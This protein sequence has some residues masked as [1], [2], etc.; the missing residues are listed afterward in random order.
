L[1]SLARRSFALQVKGVV[2]L[3]SCYRR[4][5]AKA[6][7]KQLKI[8][9]RSATKLKEVSYKLENKVIELTQTLQKRTAEKKDLQARLDELERLQQISTTKHEEAESR[10]Q[11]LH[12][13]LQRPTVPQA[14]FDELQQAKDSLD[15]RLGEAL[16]KLLDHES[17]IASLT[18]EATRNAKTLAERQRIIEDASSRSTEDAT[19]IAGLQGELSALRES[20]NRAQTLAVLNRNAP[21]PS[22]P[23]HGGLRPL[24]NNVEHYSPPPNEARPLDRKP[25][26]AANG[27]RYSAGALVGD[28][29]KSRDSADQLMIDVR[30]AHANQNRAVSVAAFAPDAVPWL[31]DLNG[32]PVEYENPDEMVMR[33]LEDVEKLDQDVLEGLI[34]GLKIQIPSLQNLPTH[35]EVVFPAHLVGL[36]TNEMWKFGMIPDAE[37]FLANVMQNIQQHVMVG[38]FLVLLPSILS[39]LARRDGR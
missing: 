24:E 35:K 28:G 20:L 33:M 3:Q 32:L 27:R 38:F 10:A 17:A 29:S 12:A 39:H 26:N 13:E 14:R 21:P 5:L 31:K 18:E 34:R 15:G 36:V 25:S 37:R 2:H 23:N 22:S 16:R 9:A 8:E 1:C 4:H 30:K 11:G 19:T 7:L 6:Q